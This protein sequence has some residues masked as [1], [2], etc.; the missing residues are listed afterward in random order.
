MKLTFTDQINYCIAGSGN[1]TSATSKTFFKRHINSNDEFVMSK[2]PTYLSESVRTFSTVASQQYYHY[3]PSVKGIKN[4]VITIGSVD[5]TLTPIHSNEKWSKLNSLSIQAGA[6]PVNYF[7]RQR[8]FG[9]FPIPQDAY[10]ATITYSLRGG[11]LVREDY[12]TGTVTVTENDETVEG[13]GG[14]AW[15]TTSNLQAD[16]WFSLTDSNGEPRGDYYRIGSVT[17]ADTL[18]LESVF[19]DSTEAGAT[20]KIGQCSELP[21]DMMEIPAQLALRDYFLSVRQSPSKA[22]S[23]GN[24]AWTG[25]TEQTSRNEKLV[26]GGLIDAIRR[27]QDRNESQI[28]NRKASSGSASSKLWASTITA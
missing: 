4:L 27:Y 16:D 12:T 8:D 3:P 13:A 2:L 7:K 22:A 17:D 20:Y 18:E 21:D 15:S 10:T 6:I 14:M 28:I 1:D 24:L 25:D 5:Y 19:E 11:G 26:K 23:W 9:F